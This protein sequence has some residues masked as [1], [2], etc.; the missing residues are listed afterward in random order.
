MKIS[1]ILLGAAMLMATPS[2]AATELVVNGGYE[3]GNISGW[4]L[5]GNTGFSSVPTGAAFTGSFGYSNGAV[6]SFGV[7]SQTVATVSGATYA[8]SFALR[9]NGGPGNAFEA[10]LGGTA[11]GPSFT[12]SGPFGYTV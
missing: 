7:L 6:G 10:S 11:F 9:N 1:A 3:T 4:T 12:N 5:T 8:Y 2:F